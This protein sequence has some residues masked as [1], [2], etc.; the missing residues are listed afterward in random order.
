MRKTKGCV[1]HAR[2]H[3]SQVSRCQIA[4]AEKTTTTTQSTTHALLL[5]SLKSFH[6]QG[7]PLVMKMIMTVSADAIFCRSILSHSTT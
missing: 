2:T 7:L 6:S 1:R 5:L 3:T 4:M